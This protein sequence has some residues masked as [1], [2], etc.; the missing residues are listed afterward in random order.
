[1]KTRNID[2]IYRNELCFQHDMPNG[3][4]KY[5]AKRRQSDKVLRDKAFKTVSGPK[6]GGYQRGLTSMVYKFFDKKSGES[7]IVNEPIYQLAN[8]PSKSK[9]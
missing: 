5:L 4:L 9:Y 8:E 6:Y 3:K 7:G 2:S 1:M